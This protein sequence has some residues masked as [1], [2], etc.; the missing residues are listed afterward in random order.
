MFNHI[1]FTILLQELNL[2]RLKEWQ[3]YFAKVY[4]ERRKWIDF[5]K[6]ISKLFLFLYNCKKRERKYMNQNENIKSEEFC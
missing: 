3:R 5:N 1:S 6:P 4:G 2:F